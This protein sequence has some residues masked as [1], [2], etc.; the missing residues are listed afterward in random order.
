MPRALDEEDPEGSY[1]PLGA[2]GQQS[3][4]V[5][6]Q[7]DATGV[8]PERRR[9]DDE[10]ALTWRDLDEGQ[11]KIL[12]DE[13]TDWFEGDAESI[14]LKAGHSLCGREGTELAC[15]A[16][17]KVYEQWPDPRKRELFKGTPQYIY[18]TTRNLYRD[19]LKSSYKRREQP[20][21]LPGQAEDEN[22]ETNPIWEKRDVVDPGWEV[23]LAINA[24]NAEKSELIFLIYWLRMSRT[25][26]A[27]HM[28][29]SR[30]QGERLHRSA[31]E[32]L[33][34]LLDEEG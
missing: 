15:N 8:S 1:Q 12:T 19:N 17:V 5:N 16:V 23:R 7:V 24:L 18:Q 10:P 21:G 33:R 11:R 34:V 31:M 6:D 13:F 28:G 2:G 9:A 20:F 26:A 25:K 4:P 27:E 22:N 29:L 3:D 14:F 30:G 32:E